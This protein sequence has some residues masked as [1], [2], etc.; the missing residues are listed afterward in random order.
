M[1]SLFFG[2]LLYCSPPPLPGHGQ[3]FQFLT[4]PSTGC[5]VEGVSV[6]RA[7]SPF[8][9]PFLLR[10]SG[11]GFRSFARPAFFFPRLITFFFF[12]PTGVLQPN[13]RFPPPFPGLRGYITSAFFT[14]TLPPFDSTCG[15]F[16]SR[17]PLNASSRTQ[18]PDLFFP[19]T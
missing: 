1:P 12:F 5:P 2:C 9:F 10:F 16:L 6:F 14:S 13:G 4:N 17:G 3:V 15:R 8:P 11:L 7:S 19:L 18:G